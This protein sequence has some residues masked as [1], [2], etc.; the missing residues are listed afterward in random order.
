M[1]PGNLDALISEL[2]NVS[3]GTTV[4]ENTFWRDGESAEAVLTLDGVELRK[5]VCC[6]NISIFFSFNQMEIIYIFIY[7]SVLLLN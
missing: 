4:G 3:G 2:R 7:S 1:I 5:W 6:I